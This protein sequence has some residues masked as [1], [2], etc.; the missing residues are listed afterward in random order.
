MRGA[1]RPFRR[2][3]AA[4]RGARAQWREPGWERLRLF[5]AGS[6][7]E[8]LAAPRPQPFGYLRPRFAYL[9]PRFGYLRLP[10]LSSAVTSVTSAGSVGNGRRR[11][12]PSGLRGE[13]RPASRNKPT[14]SGPWGGSKG[15]RTE[16]EDEA[17]AMAPPPAT[18]SSAGRAK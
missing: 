16:R 13:D 7:G 10:S 11:A 14:V 17:A 5:P 2:E 3:N 12:R 9:R 4:G 18:R 8:G 6:G 1:R 15:G